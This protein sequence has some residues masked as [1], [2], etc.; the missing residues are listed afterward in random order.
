LF[1]RTLEQSLDYNLNNAVQ[2]TQGLSELFT[3]ESIRTNSPWPFM[4][5]DFMDIYVNHTRSHPSTTSVFVCPFVEEKDMDVWS[6]YSLHHQGWL[7][8]GSMT[9]PGNDSHLNMIDGDIYD[10]T[11]AEDPTES[12]VNDTGS[13]PA[14]PIWQISPVTDASASFVN[15]NVLSEP[16]MKKSYNGI[17]ESRGMIIGPVIKN[18][19]IMNQEDNRFSIDKELDIA[20]VNVTSSGVQKPGMKRPP[21][22]RLVYPIF[23]NSLQNDA[24]AKVVG[25]IMNALS[26][27][28]YLQDILPQ[29]V[30]GIYCILQNSCGQSFT[31]LINGPNVTYEGEGDF[32]EWRYTDMEQ[33]IDLS[34]YGDLQMDAAQQNSCVYWVTVYPSSEFKDSYDSNT[35]VLFS[36]IVECAFIAMAV[37]FLIYDWTVV[38]KNE[39]IINA[40]AQSSAMVAV[41]TTAAMPS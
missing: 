7:I 32:H 41:S 27:D 16:E 30:A 39:K 23:E 2:A 37:T 4:T 24:N 34:M 31:Y 26:W 12:K 5:L 14:A 21:H 10:V 13:Y 35:P 3:A 1:A 8:E 20:V 22:S 40:A 11:F 19:Y 9:V 36:I 17:M 6:N 28:K 18:D 25:L 33:T 29:G 38:R 15:L